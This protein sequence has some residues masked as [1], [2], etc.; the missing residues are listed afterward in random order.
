MSCSCCEQ[1]ESALEKLLRLEPEKTASLTSFMDGLPLGND[2]ESNRACLIET[3]HKAQGI[4][5]YLPREVQQVIA[6]RLKITRS[7]IYGV[8]SFYSYFTDQPI[9]RFKINICCGTAC[10]VKGASKLVEEF[11]RQLKVK[12]GETTPDGRFFLGILRCVGACSLAP[13]VMVNDRVYGK[14]TPA[15]V[16]GIIADCKD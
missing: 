1:K 8:I 5:G 7:E 15:M 6:E 11:T 14:V 3:L 4:F 13:V 10:F 9:G 2:V 16:K 12:E